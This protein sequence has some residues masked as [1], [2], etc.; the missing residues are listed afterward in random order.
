MLQINLTLVLSFNPLTISLKLLS[1]LAN[2][3]ASC[4]IDLVISGDSNIGCNWNHF[5]C[6]LDNDSNTSVIF[7]KLEDHSFISFIKCCL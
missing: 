2:I 6:N 1:A 3:E 7:W 4:G 5:V